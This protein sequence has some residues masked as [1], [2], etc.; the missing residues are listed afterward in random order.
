M[1]IYISVCPF[2]VGL[3][4][5]EHADRPAEMK[6]EDKEPGA[7]KEDSFPDGADPDQEFNLAELTANTIPNGTST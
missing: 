4:G 5:G 6:D 2:P 7:P 3:K 1:W